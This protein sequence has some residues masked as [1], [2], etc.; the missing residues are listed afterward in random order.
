MK[1]DF[2]HIPSGHCENGVITNLLNYHGI[3]L[4]EPMVFGIGSGLFFAYLPFIKINGSPGSTFRPL[5][6]MIFK[7]A[8]QRLGIEMKLRTFPKQPGKAMKELDDI[9]LNQSLPV[10]LQVG[11]YHLPYFPP[12]YRFH[13]NSHN[14]AVFGK[15]DGVYHVSDPVMD[16]ATTLTEEEMRLVRYAKGVFAPKGRMYYPISI[17]EQLPLDQAIYKGLKHTTDWMLNIPIPLFGAKGIG[18]LGKRVK[19]WEQKF[20][21]RKA[22]IHLA[23]VVR[24][25]EE[26]GTGGAGFRFIYAAFLQEAADI[27]GKPVMNDFSKELTQIGDDWRV[28]SYGAAQLCKNRNGQEHT[29]Q[30]LGEL[31]IDISARE[32]KLFSQIRTDIVKPHGK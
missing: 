28:F 23:Q 12:A 9:L 26:I 17:P 3:K 31:L 1:L 27:I 2:E 30:T 8:A 32:E 20:G 7:K 15:E 19:N 4:S 24:M 14:I 5:P 21:S 6:G 10:G 16:H 29:F 18:Y 11:V 13:F 25:L 22:R